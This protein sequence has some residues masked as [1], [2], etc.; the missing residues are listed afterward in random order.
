MIGGTTVYQ[1]RMGSSFKGVIYPLKQPGLADSRLSSEQGYVARPLFHLLPTV[2]QQAYF[3]IPASQRCQ[4][5]SSGYVE[6]GLGA[7]LQKN[8]EKLHR[9]RGP[10]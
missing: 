7:T 10:C 8:P 1:E 9:L 6:A 4:L 3:L 5:G 2:H